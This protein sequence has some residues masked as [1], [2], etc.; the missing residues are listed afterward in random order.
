MNGK[1]LLFLTALFSIS[2]F[3]QTKT[4]LDKD[5][6]EPV[7]YVNIS[8]SDEKIEFNADESGQFTLPKS[9]QS[10][11]V[12]FSA[13]GYDAASLKVSEMQDTIYLESKPIALN[14]VVIG[15]R[16]KENSLTI[17]TKKAKKTWSGSGGG[18]NGSLLHARYIPF[19]PEYNTTP[20]IDK[21]RLKVDA[22]KKYTFNIRLCSVK[23]DGSPGDY[24]YGENLLVTVDKKQKY[25]EVDFSKIPIK[26]LEEGL[27]IVV[28]Y[29]TIKENRLSLTGDNDSYPAH[30]YGYGPPI[31]CEATEAMEGWSYKNGI[32][33]PNPK[34]ANGYAKMFMEITLTD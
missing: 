15:S 11:T 25:A 7:P 10:K 32:W 22:Q 12:R 17:K 4:I 2:A 18:M 8:V 31:L 24:L 19:N 30:M 29:L 14:E 16:K 28:E 1:L 6:K 9:D 23:P 26:I 13:V 27:F 5:S 3:G 21:V 33:M 20:Y 34:T